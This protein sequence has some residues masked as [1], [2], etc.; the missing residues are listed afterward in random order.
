M[1]LSLRVTP[2]VMPLVFDRWGT[3][4]LDVTALIWVL[5]SVVPFLML[6][7]KRERERERFLLFS[8]LSRAIQ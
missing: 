7:N 5:S 4:R 6:V 8:V 1:S 2:S 3:H